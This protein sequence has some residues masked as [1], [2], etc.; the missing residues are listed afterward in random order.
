MLADKFAMCDKLVLVYSA[1]ALCYVLSV[2]NSGKREVILAI[3][4]S[5]FQYYVAGPASNHML[6]L[7]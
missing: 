1:F 6:V 5:L 4:D 7:N 3:A 2:I